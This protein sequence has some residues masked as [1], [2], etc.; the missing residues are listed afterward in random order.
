MSAKQKVLIL[1]IDG[2][3]TNSKKE[4]S[5]KTLNALLEMQERGH[6][7]M[8][9]SGRPTHGVKWIADVLKLDQYGGYVLNFNG[10][11]IMNVKTKEVVYQQKFPKE[12]I[13]P[14]YEYALSHDI[15]LVTYENEKVITGTRFDPYMEAEATLN[16]MELTHVDDFINYVSFDVNKC[17][18][19]A[20]GTL[21]EHYEKELA[22]L[23]EGVLSIYRSEPYFIEAMPLGVDKAASLEHLFDI[24]GIDKADTVACGDGFNDMSMIQYAGVG[25]AMAN[26]QD[27]VKKAADVVT[28]K[29]NDEDGLLE[30]IETY[31]S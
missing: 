17:L 3:L 25:V 19:T 12:C 4:I 29:S 27:A 10:A 9:A 5:E 26:A 14:L 6:I 30:V 15:G 7:I 21:A 23:Y 8:I 20:E 18:M 11:R 16:H 28:K 1:D 31:F 13:K 22:D 2:T 24:L